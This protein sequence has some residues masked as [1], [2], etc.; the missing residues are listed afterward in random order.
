MNKLKTTKVFA[1]VFVF[2]GGLTSIFNCFPQMIDC[3]FNII[4]SSIYLGY[5]IKCQVEEMFAELSS[6]NEKRSGNESVLIVKKKN[7]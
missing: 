4:E 2:N 1:F 7:G 3:C 5:P 6:V